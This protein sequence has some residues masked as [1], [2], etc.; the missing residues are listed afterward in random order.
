MPSAKPQPRTPRS[1]PGSRPSR[2]RFLSTAI[3]C[4]ATMTGCSTTSTVN[5]EAPALVTAACP[6]DLG[7]LPDP[8][9]GTTTDKLAEV[10]A[11]YRQ[12]RAAKLGR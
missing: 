6:E 5:C 4:A 12:C 7:A 11:I 10:I 3:L 2:A 9:F 8:L 1:S